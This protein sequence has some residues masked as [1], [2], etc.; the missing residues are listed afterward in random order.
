MSAQLTWEQK[1][2]AIIAIGPASLKCRGE[3]DWYVEQSG[4]EVGDGRFLTSPSVSGK[5]PADAV[6]LYWD[7][8]TDLP[9][10]ARIVIGAYGKNRREVRWNGFMWADAA[11]PD[12]KG[13]R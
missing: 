9:P 6:A 1:F 4:V 7:S 10:S 3:G 11:S 13:E 2:L 5:A 8:L 12:G